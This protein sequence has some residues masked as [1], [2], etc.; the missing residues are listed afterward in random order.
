MAATD[1]DDCKDPFYGPH[2]VYPLKFQHT[3]GV[4]YDY[5]GLYELRID[6]ADQVYVQSLPRPGAGAGRRLSVTNDQV[7]LYKN[8]QTRMFQVHQLWCL[9]VLGL[10]PADGHRYT[11]DHLDQDHS[12]NSPYNF[13]WATN[14]QQNNNRKKRVQKMKSVPL[15]DDELLVERKQ[16]D[17]RF[18]IETGYKV[19]QTKDGTWLKEV[20]RVTDGGGYLACKVNYKYRRFNRIIAHLF[21]GDDGIKLTDID[22]KTAIIEH[23]DDD[24]T[25]NHKNNLRVSTQKK[26]VES[27]HASGK[28]T[29]KRVYAMAV[30]DETMRLEFDS[31]AEASRKIAKI[32]S[33]DIGKV[34]RGR[35]I[36]CGGFYWKFEPFD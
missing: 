21:G 32:C 12:N 33:S 14:W 30:D 4:V 1:D 8:R 13:R 20:D 34:C 18:F 25:N 16:L 31:A 7:K 5:T 36:T 11:V 28:S 17:G 26:N 35:K 24:K 22:D 2:R 15:T 23:L 27:W 9:V 19:R 6:D 29:R 3:D 10:P